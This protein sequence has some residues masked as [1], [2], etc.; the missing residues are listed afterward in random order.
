[1]RRLLGLGALV[2]ACGAS[3]ARARLLRWT[4]VAS[5]VISPTLTATAAASPASPILAANAHPYGASFSEWAARWWQW[6]LSQPVP[7]NPVLDT[8]GAL[9][10]EGQSGQVWFLAGTFSGSAVTRSCT[11][12][13]GTALLVPVLNYVYCAFT[14]DP[15]EQQTE[16]FV[17]DQ[18]AF[19]A[20]EASGLSATIDGHAAPGIDTSFGESAL[21]RVV[22]PADNIFGLP[23][24]S[25]LAPCVDA[26]FYLMVAPCRSATIRSTS[27]G[28]WAP[29]QRTRATRSRSLRRHDLDRDRHDGSSDGEVADHGANPVWRSRCAPCDGVR[30]CVCLRRRA[31][32][33]GA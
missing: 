3:G 24:G 4:L 12:E 27:P 6:A 32:A 10:A 22:L 15:P 14:T 1:M 2:A 19:V 21:F 16:E 17:R 23:A 11:I 25:V 29:L 7:T 31:E 9:C 26:G 33:G 5:M 28:R 13:V 30:G 8:T 18:V 20:A